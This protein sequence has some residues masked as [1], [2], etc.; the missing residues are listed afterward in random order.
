[1]GVDTGESAERNLEARIEDLQRRL[2]ESA[3]RLDETEALARVGS[4]EWELPQLRSTWSKQLLRIFGRDPDGL[5]P[6]IDELVA[7]V[8]PDDRLGFKE[9]VA[10]VRQT[11]GPFRHSYRIIDAD[12]EIHHLRALGQ[13]VT[14]SQG[15]PT[16]SYGTTQDI[17]E[18]K[19]SEAQLDQARR[20]EAVGQ[21]V[22]GV[23]HDF[24]NLLSVILNRTECLIADGR[25]DEA[26]SDLR[27]VE[28]AATTATDLTRRL[29]LFSRR[30]PT[31]LRP[32]DLLASVRE[33]EVLLRRTIGE[34]IELDV[35][36]EGG[37]PAVSLGTGH[38]EQVLINLAVNAR[39]AMPDGGRIAISLR[40]L[41]AASDDHTIANLPPGEPHVVLSVADEG[42]GMAEETVAQAFDPFFT[43]K[44]RE[45]GT[46]LGLAT[47][48]GIVSQ[49]G[50]QIAIDSKPN[51]GT[52]VSVYLP[53]VAAEGADA[54]PGRTLSV[55]GE[56]ETVLVVD[57]EEAVRTVVCH[58][59]ERHGY[60]TIDAAGG[61]EAEAILVGEDV[62]LLLTDVLMPG[63][64]GGELVG[65]LHSLKPGLRAI[66]M[67]GYVGSGS[68]VQPLGK[69]AI[70]L[71][72]PFTAPQLIAAVGEVL[73]H[74]RDT[75]LR[76]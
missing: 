15:R 50:G 34:Q 66:Y 24:N 76:E 35:E 1:M 75:A 36:A 52:V 14:D 27:E 2:E 28:R 44:P 37:L 59:L 58:M 19:R 41:D 49:A 68:G 74:G 67:S 23:A 32:V 26:M 12:G 5:P 33:A 20:L 63:M 61:A 31:D 38:A 53:A 8:H 54:K 51:Q 42:V 69:G 71:E 3:R 72:K 40:C 57:N 11:P 39:D 70:I 47:V 48:Y 21:L 10:K 56:G 18:L 45:K 22:G 16:R 30:E 25:Y 43:T 9:L 4:W 6:T 62:D 64:S 7:A 55:A 60:R 65:R 13:T 29:L 46:G 73:A 17:S